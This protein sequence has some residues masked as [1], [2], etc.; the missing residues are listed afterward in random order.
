[1]LL[2]KL[3]IP[4]GFHV[5]FPEID[6]TM[7]RMQKYSF[8]LNSRF[9]FLRKVAPYQLAMVSL[10]SVLS[11]HTYLNYLSCTLQCRGSKLWVCACIACSAMH[12]VYLHACKHA[13]TDASSSTRTGCMQ[14]H[15]SNDCSG[16]SRCFI[17]TNIQ[18]IYVRYYTPTAVAGSRRV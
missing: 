12:T 3:P 8:P 17:C 1:V 14:L 18:L 6:V 13:C 15:Y 11:T 7:G 9:D 4:W 2:Q 16:E 5:P 10:A